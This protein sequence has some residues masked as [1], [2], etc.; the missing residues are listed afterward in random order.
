MQAVGVFRVRT[1]YLALTVPF[2]FACADEPGAEANESETAG[3]GDALTC[4]VAIVGAGAGGLH[5]AYRLAPTLGEGV[6][7]FEREDTLG[8][9]IHDIALDP[10]DPNS[11]TIGTGARRVMEGQQ[12]LFDLADELEL[13]LETPGAAIDLINARGAFG[14]AKDDFVPLYDFTPDPEPDV[15]QETYFYDQLRFGPAREMIDTYPNFQAYVTD[16]IGEEGYAFLRDMSRFRADFEYDLD[17]RG[18]LDWLDEEWDTCCIPSYPV[19]GMS[20][21]IRG[22]ADSTE[23][24]G[25]RI[26][27]GEAV[28]SIRRVESG[29]YQ[30]ETAG[31]IV[32]AQKVVIAIPPVALNEVDGDIVEEIKAQDIYQDIVGVKVVTITQWWPESWWADVVD[33][34]LTMDNHVWRAWTDEHCLNFIEIPIEPYAA[35]AQVTRSV[36]NDN[37]ECSEFWE[38]TAAEGDAAVEAEVANGLMHLFNDNGITSPAMIDLPVPLHTHVQVWPA[39]W[40]WLASG[41]AATNDELFEWAAEPLPGEEIGLVG[42]AYNVNRSGWSDGAYK[43][44]INLLNTHYGM[45]LPGL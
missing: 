27:T 4:E 45:S 42:E 29:G 12:I 31:H 16:V 30:L 6:C 19:G 32:N 15:D 10:A 43:S 2:L 1:L 8:G 23:Q 22:M 7:L 36:Y 24:A 38:A 39:A 13:E 44:S 17:A 35:A 5:T 34:N 41:T 26:F 25:G 28:T 18:Y 37:L 9:R 40:H 33:P 14:F 20:A 3:D 21:F 11:Q